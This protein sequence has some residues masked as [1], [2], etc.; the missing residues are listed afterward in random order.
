MIFY[1]GGG[2]RFNRRDDFGGRG[3]ARQGGGRGGGNWGNRGFNDRQGNRGGGGGR[4]NNFRDRDDDDRGGRRDNWGNNNR[5]FENRGAGGNGGRFQREFDN[6]GGGGGGGNRFFDRDNNRGGAGGNRFPEQDRFNNQRDRFGRDESRRINDNRGDRDS[7]A[8]GRGRNDRGSRDRLSRDRDSRSRGR[9]SDSPVKRRRD[10]SDSPPRRSRRDSE[11]RG[12]YKRDSKSRSRG[13]RDSRSRSISRPKRDSESRDRGNRGN[14]SRPRP[15]RDS[16]PPRARARSSESPI[17]RKRGRNS[18]ERRPPPP[19]PAPERRPRRDDSF[20]DRKPKKFEKKRDASEE[21]YEWGKK[22]RGSPQNGDRDRKQRSPDS[23]KAKPNF[24][25]TGKLAEDT[26]KVNGIIIKYSEPQ[27]SR[28]PKR[29][30]RLYPFKGEETLPTM[31]IHRQSCYLIGRDRKVCDLPVDHPSCSKQHAV[32]Q[33]RLVPFER[34]NGTIGKRVR[35]YLI[36]LDSAN[37]TFINNKQIDARKYYEVLE[38][39]VLKFGFSSREY[40]MLHENSK[41]DQE[42]D[43]IIAD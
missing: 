4:F 2:D 19:E 18:N 31:Y 14:G 26:N 24:E 21:N 40:V 32:L 10:D 5:S 13:R 16:P 17:S 30:W 12:R 36:D 6:N 20:D 1:R 37:G 35:P 39:D 42:D 38:K 9:R 29:R 41:E 33:Y 27:E 3:G 7:A 43:D 8:G 11:S 34:D 28:K 15:P 25:L 23:D 22:S